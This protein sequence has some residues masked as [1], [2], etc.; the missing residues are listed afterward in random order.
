MLWIWGAYGKLFY[1][2]SE[3]AL[4]L[5]KKEKLINECHS[6]RKIILGDSRPM[7]DMVPNV[8]GPEYLNLAIGGETPIELYHS[9][10]MMSYCKDK[11][12]SIFIS[13]AP[14]HF[15]AMES[16]WGRT[17]PFG[18]LSLNEALEVQRISQSDSVQNI[19]KKSATGRINDTFKTIS[20]LI[21][22]PTF[23][24]TKIIDGFFKSN[25]E[26]NVWSLINLSENRG[27][28]AMTQSIKVS[29]PSAEASMGKFVPLEISDVYM[30]LAL[31]ELKKMDVHVY[32]LDMPITPIT[33]ENLPFNYRDDYANYLDQLFS[34]YPN[35]KRIGAT[36]PVY[37]LDGFSDPFHLNFAASI[38]FSKQLKKHLP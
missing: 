12:D 19:Y 16:Y 10:K 14:F 31:D 35:V 34:N 29:Q 37:S 6:G 27:H 20:I 21:N 23:Y 26:L 32:Y 1:M 9:I 36:L 11:P 22:L 28:V 13:M 33:D 8:L 30:K 24:Y 17:L 3:Y 15:M 25:V 5:Y 18:F 4:W 38:D 7:A 2:D